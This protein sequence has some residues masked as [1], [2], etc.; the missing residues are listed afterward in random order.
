MFSDEKLQKTRAGLGNQEKA[1]GRS[2]FW[3]VGDWKEKPGLGV[4]RWHRWTG[5]CRSL[6][7]LVGQQDIFAIRLE[8]GP[9]MMERE[10][11]WKGQ[12]WKCGNFSFNYKY[13]TH[14]EKL[15]ILTGVVYSNLILFSVLHLNNKKVFI[16]TVLAINNSMLCIY[17]RVNEQQKH[18]QAI[19][20]SRFKKL[21]TY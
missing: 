3:L 13:L 6:G 1:Q 14:K 7:V 8:W 12:G 5:E 11:T 18:K 9:V 15:H 17:L 20:Q 16:V 21:L 2:K 10:V 19:I 4:R